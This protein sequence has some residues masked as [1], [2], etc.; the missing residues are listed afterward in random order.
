MPVRTILV[1]GA[2]VAG[3]ACALACARGGVQVRVFEAGETLARTPG[4]VDI[5][6]N[7]L[8][9]LAAFG[10]AEECVRLGFAY[11]GVDVVDERGEQG[12]RIDTPHLAGDRLPAAAGIAHDALLD[13]LARSAA[14]AG[15]EVRTGLHVDGIDADSGRVTA[16][17]TAHQADLVVLACGA[18]SSLVGALFEV[19]RCPGA[20][21]AW[22]H[23]LL[24]RP[25]QL[26]R[27]TWMAGT[28]GHRFALV[29][30]GLSSAGIAVVRTADMHGASDGAALT[31]TLAGWG[32]MSRRIAALVDPQAP[33]VLRFTSRGLV[34]GPWYRGAVLCIG[35]AAHGDVPTF[36][37]SAAQGVEDAR[38]LGEL[39][40]AGTDRATLLTH[41][42]KRRWHRA[43][44]VHELVKQAE[45]WIERPEPATDLMALA[46][47]L[48][49][50]VA[51]PA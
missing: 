33:T 5:V 47:E 43:H 21:R 40:C 46:R 48:H 8:R 7:L 50:L 35:A 37:Q 20:A 25:A 3:L 16:A 41:Y 24:P 18:G 4:H 38:V 36:G 11:S 30:I 14:A 39:I 26:D 1:V 51:Q 44:R 9:D 2:G 45:R 17:G 12:F 19:Q 29:P 23:A 34:E 10:L 27:P 31:Q 32:A 15:V 42:M 28:H 13:I 22:W 6:P 49:A